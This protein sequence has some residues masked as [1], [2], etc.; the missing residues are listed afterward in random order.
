MKNVFL[1]FLIMPLISSSQVLVDASRGS[2]VPVDT[3]LLNNG[4]DW[5]L[6]GSRAPF[7]KITKIKFDRL[8][9]ISSNEKGFRVDKQKSHEVDFTKG[10]GGITATINTV[11]SVSR[12]VTVSYNDTEKIF[13]H[14]LMKTYTYTKRPSILFGKQDQPYETSVATYWNETLIIVN[15]KK[16]SWH[17]WGLDMLQSNYK[18]DSFEIRQA[19]GFRIGKKKRK[20]IFGITKG[21][22]FLR[23]GNQVACV[24][25]YPTAHVWIRKD[26]SEEYKQVLGAAMIAVIAAKVN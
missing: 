9:A 19:T 26:L 25:T 17:M 18:E 7:R 12:T 10:T 22:V 15:N 3:F 5:H 16:T 4:D 24:E 20:D 11:D 21:Y 2:S 23:D 13:I 14:M 1:L 6:K 8:K